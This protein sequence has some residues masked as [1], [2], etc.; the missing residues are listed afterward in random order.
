MF[1]VEAAFAASLDLSSADED[2]TRQRDKSD[3]AVSQPCHS[4][5]ASNGQ[6]CLFR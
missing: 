5:N 3:L 6:A 1:Y 2:R 4:F